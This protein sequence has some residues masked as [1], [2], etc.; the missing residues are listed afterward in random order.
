MRRPRKKR[1]KNPPRTLLIIIGGLGDASFEGEEV[2][3]VP[4]RLLGLIRR[5]FGEP[6]KLTLMWEA[7]LYSKKMS[8]KSIRSDDELDGPNRGRGD[9]RRRCQGGTR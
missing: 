7:R 5:D 3:V 8:L 1:K 2:G 4:F 6:M 9:G